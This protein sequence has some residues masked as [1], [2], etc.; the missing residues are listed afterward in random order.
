[1]KET[2]DQG[3]LKHYCKKK[4][5]QVH[6]YPLFQTLIQSYSNKKKK[7]PWHKIREVDQ[8]N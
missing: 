6:Y 4:K 1:M 2:K 5:N 8:W 7:C 3:Y